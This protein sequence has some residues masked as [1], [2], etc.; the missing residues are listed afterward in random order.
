MGG[1]APVAEVTLGCSTAGQPHPPQQQRPITLQF[2]DSVIGQNGDRWEPGPGGPLPLH[3]CSLL[4]WMP[5]R[6]IRAEAW[7][8]S[9]AGVS[10]FWRYRNYM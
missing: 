8:L 10:L 7:M 6:E 2:S 9:R 5:F 4:G 1:R 3:V